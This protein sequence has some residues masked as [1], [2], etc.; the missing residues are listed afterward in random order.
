M[1]P[2]NLNFIHA[3]AEDIPID[4]ETQDLVTA[5]F[6]FH[7]V[8]QEPSLNIINQAYRVLRPG[9]TI[10]IIDLD[11]ERLLTGLN[12]NIFRKWAFEITEPH[13][14]EYYQTDIS[15]LL[16]EAQFTKIEK[17]VN[18]PFNTIWLGTK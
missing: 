5:Q 18:D 9:G 10:A 3:N 14:K 8:P 2:H 17:K 16:K 12:N 15:E 6:L 11:P 4:N 13:I 7:E 1:N